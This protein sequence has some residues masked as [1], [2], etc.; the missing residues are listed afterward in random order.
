MDFKA[1]QK[2]RFIRDNSCGGKHYGRKGEIVEVRGYSDSLSNAV[3][4]AFD[5]PRHG[6]Y[7]P[8]A[9]VDDLVPVTPE[10]S[11]VDTDF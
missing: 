8:Y 4:I 11:Y 5:P 9:L 1:G 2:V 3:V 7:T 6:T 10:D